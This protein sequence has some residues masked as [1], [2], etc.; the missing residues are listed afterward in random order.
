MRK[1]QADDADDQNTEL[2]QIG[3]CDHAITS[4]FAGGTTVFS[5]SADENIISYIVELCQFVVNSKNP[6]FLTGF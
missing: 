4:P 1:A 3:I 6:S 5:S 2:K